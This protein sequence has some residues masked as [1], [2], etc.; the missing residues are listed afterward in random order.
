MTVR[1][2]FD[3]YASCYDESRRRL[4]PCFDEFYGVALDVIPFAPDGCNQGIGLGCGH[5][6]NGENGRPAL[7]LRT[8]HPDGYFPKNVVRGR[9]RA[10]SYPDRFACIV[11]DYAGPR[12][13]HKI[14]I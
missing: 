3:K 4:I 8:C 2:V 10:A 6:F 1:K 11:A 13:F 7:S 5:R 14:T 12:H 9:G